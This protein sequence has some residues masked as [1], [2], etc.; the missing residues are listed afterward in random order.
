MNQFG[1]FSVLICI[2]VVSSQCVNKESC[3]DGLLRKYDK[4]GDGFLNLE[5]YNNIR[6]TTKHKDDTTGA[7]KKVQT[8]EGLYGADNVSFSEIDK[9]KN[10]Q[11]NKLD[12][13]ELAVL[14][15]LLTDKLLRLYKPFIWEF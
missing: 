3:V 12:K 5:E 6:I 2:G 7:T 13:E 15:N 4:N 11:N 8:P 1:L 14:C 10:G 9:T